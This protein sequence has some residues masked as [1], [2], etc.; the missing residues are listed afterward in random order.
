MMVLIET[1]KWLGQ[2]VDALQ[3]QASTLSE[4]EKKIL[5]L[6]GKVRA[7]LRPPAQAGAV[8]QIGN[9]VGTGISQYAY[10]GAIG[11]DF[12]AAGN[13]LAL[14]QRW[15]AQTMHKGSPRRALV[16]ASTTTFVL[17]AIR[18]IAADG[19]LIVAFKKQLMATLVGHLSSVATYV[20]LNPFVNAWL[21]QTADNI[22]KRHTFEIQLDAKIAQLYFKRG[23][24]QSGQSWSDYL[25]GATAEARVASGLYLTAFKK[26]YDGDRP[27]ETLCALPSAAEL[28]T[29]Y[30]ALADVLT[31]SPLKERLERYTG[32]DNLFEDLPEEVA[33]AL[34]LRFDQV[35]PARD[36]LESFPGNVPK[37]NADFLEDAFKNTRHWALDAGYDHGPYPVKYFLWTPLILLG[38]WYTIFSIWGNITDFGPSLSFIY[39]KLLSE[40]AKKDHEE[41]KQLYQ[42]G[43]IN[44]GVLSNNFD[45][46][47]T[48]LFPVWFDILDSSYSTAGYITLFVNSLLAGPPIIPWKGLFGQGTADVPF[49]SFPSLYSKIKT[50]L[51]LTTALWLDQWYPKFTRHAAWRWLWWIANVVAD[52]VEVEVVTRRSEEKGKEGDELGRQLWY[53][54]LWLAGTFAVSS[55]FVLLIRGAD[56]RKNA[57]GSIDDSLNFALYYLFLGSLVPL[58]FMV[59]KVWIGNDFDADLLFKLTG[60]TWPSSDTALV[61]DYLV[62]QSGNQDTRAVFPMLKG[63]QGTEFQ[64]HLFEANTLLPGPGD[65]KHYPQDDTT[66]VWTDRLK[67]DELERRKQSKP[68]P[69]K[70]R[71]KGLLD[72]AVYFSGLLAMAAVNFDEATDKTAVQQIFQDWNLDYRTVDEWHSLMDTPD[73]TPGLLVAAERWWQGVQHPP[74]ASD[75]AARQ[76][77]DAARQRL[78][79][80]FA[81]LPSHYGRVEDRSVAPRNDQADT[82]HRSLASGTPFTIV[83][84]D[85]K[86]VHTGMLDAHGGFSVTLPRGQDYELRIEHYEGLQT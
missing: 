50:V 8:A 64:V 52:G 68:F 3:K 42:Q 15:V 40:D 33:A 2:I 49:F 26:T 28:A 85:G 57:D 51:S 5:D 80:A 59:W 75:N 39:D 81:N 38:S 62:E 43:W 16:K 54:Q 13:I 45:H 47:Q 76:R 73:A 37:L 86:V 7:Y 41:L 1:E 63:D 6:A 30:P 12:V 24:L 77:L 65:N 29:K 60:A 19:K 72:R 71:L 67:N 58:L 66:K 27:L 79:T 61:S 23:D 18:Q 34:R 35:K 82:G 22:E 9:G 25:P 31:V 21:W 46:G 70:Y 4:P 36:E 17:H 10:L 74:A 20:V 53:L 69:E 78:A 55:L 11:H 44:D 14:N 84:R 83:D 48:A 32:Y 56:S